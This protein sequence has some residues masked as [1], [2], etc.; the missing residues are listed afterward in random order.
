MDLR[1]KRLLPVVLVLVPALFLISQISAYSPD[2]VGLYDAGQVLISS[3]NY[4]DAVYAFDR[5]IAIEPGFFEAW[6]EK[7]DALNRA[8][9]YS[10]ALNASDHSLALNQTYVAGWIN[11]GYIL[12]NLGKY[13]DEITAY[14]TAIAI[15]PKSPEAWFNKGYA[16]AA[17]GRYDEA[18][19]SFDRVA[20]LNP[21]YPNLQANRDI[22]VRNRNA[23]TPFV[24]RYSPWLAL[25]CFIIVG[26]GWRVYNK[27]QRG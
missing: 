26:Y 21:M 9:R 12:Y 10:D 5:A 8:H 27:R 3:G 20:E 25:V 23:S 14:E 15:D 7:A 13:E 24:V 18:I 17:M 22:A 16:L 19:R 2:A 1:E 11:R 4:T 6:N